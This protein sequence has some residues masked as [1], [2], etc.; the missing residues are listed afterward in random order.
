MPAPE[1]G[2]APSAML[3][4]GPIRF[5]SLV[6]RKFYKQIEVVGLENVPANGG[7]LFAGNHPNALIDGL[8]L[9]SQAG[10]SPVHLLGNAQLWKTPLLARLLDALGA[11]PVLR[12]EG[13]GPDADT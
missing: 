4:R 8:L 5:L 12:R 10:R 6:A 1:I 13:H 11:V 9:I 3:Y 2:T 7:V